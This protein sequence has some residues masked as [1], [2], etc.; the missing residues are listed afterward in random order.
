MREIG[1][2]TGLVAEV[3][4]ILEIRAG[5]SPRRLDVWL[6]CRPAGGTLRLGVEVE[7]VRFF[8]EHRELFLP[9]SFALRDETTPSR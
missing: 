6:L 2:E 1:E 4:R 3:E 5:R 9:G 8:A 7:E